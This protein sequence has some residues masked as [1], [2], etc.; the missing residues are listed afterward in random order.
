MTLGL[1]ALSLGLSVSS[2]STGLSRSAA[3]VQATSTAT[4]TATI[5]TVS[6]RMGDCVPSPDLVHDL[7][8]IELGFDRIVDSDA[9]FEARVFC[10]SNSLRIEIWPTGGRRRIPLRE[11]VREGGPRLVALNITELAQDARKPREDVAQDTLR[12]RA[13][14]SSAVRVLA[15][16]T[17]PAFG[18]RFG[19][20]FDASPLS[21]FPW[22]THAD[23]G[24]EQ[25]TSSLELG[26]L[27]ARSIS[28][29]LLAGLR[30]DPGSR[31][32]L[33]S[34]L[35]A[36]LG[37]V[38]LEGRGD[39]NAVMTQSGSGPWFGPVAAARIRYGGRWGVALGI[40]AG[41]TATSVFGQIDS[42]RVG[43]VD[44]WVGA[45]LTVDWGS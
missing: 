26:D 25:S 34:W 31:W 44:G 42:Q 33:F 1:W 20:G 6:L 27:R 35:G 38:W 14:L 7:V 37:W 9:A 2:S 24:F 40:E 5:D 19:G 39:P 16:P 41:W 8:A 13:G 30:F 45:D 32:S 22:S 4:Q 12:Y 10:E 3:T 28:G 15:A 29:R 23:L 18:V 11:V 36:R 43:L 21:S 17:R